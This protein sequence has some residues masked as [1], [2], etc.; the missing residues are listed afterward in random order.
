MAKK[1]KPKAEMEE[2]V[3]ELA[4]ILT[5]NP[6]IE[7]RIR[8]TIEHHVKEG[9]HDST[10]SN[11]FRGLGI[12]VGKEAVHLIMDSLKTNSSKFFQD[13]KEQIEGESI[14]KVLPFLQYLTAL[15]GDGIEK[16]YGV[17]G[18][19]PDDWR[20]ARVTAFRRREDEKSWFIELDLTKINGG[21][22]YLRM[23]PRSAL[24]LARH[25]LREIGR[26]PKEVIS[27]P[28]IKRFNEETKAFQEKF[29]GNSSKEN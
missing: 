16:A 6:L 23:P 10:Y 22:V 20:R 9:I 11:I 12:L 24:Q 4:Q 17:Y 5:D 27:K 29:L 1:A 25:F 21:K 14:D 2:K 8:E 7:Q 28:A 26:V 19:E 13:I 18:E 15:Y 3:T